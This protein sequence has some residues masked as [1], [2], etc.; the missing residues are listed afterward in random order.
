MWV[1]RS[2]KR[3]VLISYGRQD[4]TWRC[5]DARAG[6]ERGMA[7]C[8]LVLFARPRHPEPDMKTFASGVVGALVV[9][10]RVAEAVVACGQ[11]LAQS[12]RVVEFGEIHPGPCLVLVR[13]VGVGAQAESEA[14]AAFRGVLVSGSVS[15]GIRG[16]GI[17]QPKGV[18]GRCRLQ[19]LPRRGR[20]FREWW[21][22]A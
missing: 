1:L 9:G 5:S 14:L 12:P 8:P 6:A 7:T 22:G 2:R 15:V 17:S 11:E 4:G 19:I 10:V 18:W 16:G 13:G 20:L 3:D 21:S